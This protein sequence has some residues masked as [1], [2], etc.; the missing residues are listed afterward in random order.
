MARL[1]W[2]AATKNVR[3]RKYRLVSTKIPLISSASF[4]VKPT[5]RRR[6][7]MSHVSVC[8]LQKDQPTKLLQRKNCVLHVDPEP[9]SPQR[10]GVVGDG[11]RQLCG[12]AVD[13]LQ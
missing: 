4:S 5:K 8:E 11:Q 9:E 3:A 13:L 1:T 12:G 7:T 2:K 6:V 10:D